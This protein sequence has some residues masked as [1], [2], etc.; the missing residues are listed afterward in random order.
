MTIEMMVGM[1]DQASSSGSEPSM[2]APISS[3]C[4]RRYRMA[5]NTTAADTATVKKADT[6]TMK[7]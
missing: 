7:M 3:A 1:A 6:A 4:L 2:W 5:K